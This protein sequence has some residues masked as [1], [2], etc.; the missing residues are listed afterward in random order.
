MER[1]KAKQSL[2]ILPVFADKLA[3]DVQQS[4]AIESFVVGGRSRR[5]LSW[6]SLT[7]DWRRRRAVTGLSN[8]GVDGANCANPMS[9]AKSFL[10]RNWNGSEGLASKITC[11]S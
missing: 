9:S 1:L 3:S 6:P 11:L 4:R 5:A 8:C 2:A 10:A 7:I